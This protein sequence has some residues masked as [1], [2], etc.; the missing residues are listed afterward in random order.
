[1]NPLL[2]RD[3]KSFSEPS[4]S[5]RGERS[6][7][8]PAR[9][10]FGRVLVPMDLSRASVGG[11]RYAARVAQTFGGS[12]WPIYVQE[13]ASLAGGMESVI[14]AVSD[15]EAAEGASKLL[16]RFCREA[17]D[18]SRRGKI[19]VCI[20]QP[21]HEITA[22]VY[23]LDIDLIVMTTH[24]YTGLQHVGHH[25]IAERVV[26]RSV[27][28]VLTVHQA[29]LEGKSEEGPGPPVT[30]KSILVPVDLTESVRPV[31]QYAAALA[32]N[33]GGSITLFYEVGTRWAN[34][35]RATRELGLTHD[36]TRSLA[37]RL[38]GV[39]AHLETSR[40]EAVEK[41]VEIA[42]PDTEAIVQAARRLSSDLIVMGKH[43][44]SWWKHLGKA[45]VAERVVRTARCPVL[46]V[47]EKAHS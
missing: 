24:G 47:P 44:C 28:P 7:L 39:K 46:S 33:C 19:M 9:L 29:L 27:C 20:G 18:A 22:A 37:E 17:V 10:K 8:S 1:M 34:G 31:L 30:W 2:D 43:D 42:H 13:P 25:S 3:M 4:V 12:I 11:L 41:P 36:E 26:W 35:S 38:V 15:T 23:S 6:C 16:A 14:T 21:V 40:T 5:E 32:E 45:A